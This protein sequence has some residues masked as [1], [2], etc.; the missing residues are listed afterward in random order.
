[1]ICASSLDFERPGLPGRFCVGPMP[2]GEI[3]LGDA[4]GVPPV[5]L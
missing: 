1:M 3:L 2:S 4:D 5:D